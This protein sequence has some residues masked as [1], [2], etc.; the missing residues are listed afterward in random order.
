MTTGPGTLVARPTT[1]AKP[2][3]TSRTTAP[4]T[5]PLAED[6]Q[7]HRPGRAAGR[8]LHGDRRDRAAAAATL[9]GPDVARGAAR[10]RLAALI[11]RRACGAAASRRRRVAAVDRGAAAEER[12]RERR[13]AVVGERAELGVDRGRVRADL[14]AVHAVDEARTVVPVT[15]EA[16]PLGDG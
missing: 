12:V 11:R 10:P 3:R 6:A 16:V 9:D 4:V 1:S 5:K 7:L 14:V 2:A 15:D 13:P 8:R